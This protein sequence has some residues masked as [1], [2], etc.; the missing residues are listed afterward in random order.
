[1]N[2]K[3][4]LQKIGPVFSW[5][6]LSNKI[7][8]LEE[9]VRIIK[10]Q[11]AWLE[12]QVKGTSDSAKPDQRPESSKRVFHF[13]QLENSSQSSFSNYQSPRAERSPK[14]LDQE[15]RQKELEAMRLKLR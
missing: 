15:R 1:M 11:I 10:D 9:R 6:P 3:E 2:L 13:G 5:Q 7:P 14:D 4:R 8:E 12:P